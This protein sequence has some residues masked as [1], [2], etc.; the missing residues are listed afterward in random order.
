MFPVELA[1]TCWLLDGVAV[2]GRVS[3]MVRPPRFGVVL[4]QR[5]RVP[6]LGQPHRGRHSGQ[7]A[8]DYH[9]MPS[10]H[11]AMVIPPGCD[12]MNQCGISSPARAAGMH[13]PVAWPRSLTLF[14]T[15]S[16]SAVSAP[17]GWEGCHCSAGN[18]ATDANVS[19]VLGGPADAV[20]KPVG[21]LLRP[22]SQ[23][24]TRVVFCWR[25]ENGPQSGEP[26]TR[27]GG[28]V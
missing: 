25:T 19:A 10:Y 15:V 22:M 26:K 28:T 20:A 7:P 24:I 14:S 13:Q 1:R 6:E 9:H 2:L 11:A 4:Q 16:A 21:L 23:N 8:A 3:P 5:H 27:Q 18:S 17:G 12:R